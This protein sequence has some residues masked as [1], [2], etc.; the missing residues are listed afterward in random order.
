MWDEV[1]KFD[2][3]KGKIADQITRAIDSVGANL[4]EGWARGTEESVRAVLQFYRYSL[5]SAFESL[6]WLER[7]IARGSITRTKGIAMYKELEAAAGAL[8]KYM[9][10]LI[11]LE[12][13]RNKK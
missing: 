8:Q 11:A 10:E 1:H 3:L 13:R 2:G 5:G 7:L 12:I 4:V 9:N 6:Y